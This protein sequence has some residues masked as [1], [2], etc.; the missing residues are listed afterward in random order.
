MIRLSKSYALM[1]CSLSVGLLFSRFP[2]TALVKNNDFHGHETDFPFKPDKIISRIIPFL[3][4]RGTRTGEFLIDSTVTYG[5]AEKDQDYPAIAF[6]DSIYLIAWLDSRTY[7]AQNIVGARVNQAGVLLDS[8]GIVISAAVGSQYYLDI[9]SD[10]DNFLVVWMDARNSDWDIFGTRISS[11]GVILDPTGIAISSAS[12]NQGEPK[13]A[14]DGANYFV[15]WCDDRSG[16]LDV[17]GSRV[18]PSGLVLDPAGIQITSM[19]NTQGVGGII[20]GDSTYLVVWDDWRYSNWDIYGARVTPS[21]LVLDPNGFK[22]SEAPGDQI[23]PEVAFDGSNYLIAWHDRRFGSYDVYCTRVNQFGAVLDTNGI[24]IHQTGD[25]N[26]WFLDIAFDDSNYLVCWQDYNDSTAYDI[27][28]AR[29]SVSGSVLDTCG[30]IISNQNMWDGS[31]S[32]AFGDSNYMIVWEYGG[33]G[34]FSSIY[35]AR[36]GI[37]GILIDTCSVLISMAANHQRDPVAM[38]D[39]SNYLVVWTE[40]RSD[41]MPDIYGMRISQSGISVDSVS[42]TIAKAPGAQWFPAMDFIDPDYFVVWEDYRSDYYNGDIY[43]ARIAM[44]GS[45]IDTAGIIISNAVGTQELPAISCDSVNHLVVWTDRRNGDYDIYGS[46]INQSGTVLDPMGIPISSTVNDQSNPSIIFGGTDYFIVWTDFRSGAANIYGA[47]VAPDGTV[48]DPT[49]IA[50]T[51]AALEQYAPTVGFDGINYLVVWQDYR[52]HAWD[53]YG[54]RVTQAGILI[55]T[56]GIPISTAAYEQIAPAVAFDGLNYIIVWAD[57]RTGGADLDIYGAKMNPSGSIIEE[58]VVSDQPGQQISPA[59]AHGAGNRMLVTYSCW[60][61]SINTHAT[62]TM[63]IWGKLYPFVGLEEG[64]LNKKVVEPDLKIYP[65]PAKGV[66]NIEYT[67][68]QKTNVGISVYDLAGKLINKTVEKNQGAG[69]HSMELNLA[70]LPQG[71]YFVKLDAGKYSIVNKVI[72]VRSPN[73]VIRKY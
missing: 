61:D 26:Q 68:L 70:N 65:N 60:T 54:A 22:I 41:S 55:D 57:R 58:F 33:L 44:S 64:T 29:V 1:F 2:V 28:G 56:G 25:G 18:S 13:V 47:R 3:G 39:G 34:V 66:Y 6:N 9:A 62:N 69:I 30:I 17:Y 12:G 24:L 15:V 59:L 19:P 42:I 46:R 51:T 35:G 40:S 7:Y 45:V 5:Q 14:F 10:G 32:A 37:D 71:V 4:S 48:L 31:V 67:L 11:T 63:R 72:N 20:F 52:N 43:G 49:G 16:D 38:F 23:Y 50:I 73:N 36:L 21:G 53:I 8:V 27:W